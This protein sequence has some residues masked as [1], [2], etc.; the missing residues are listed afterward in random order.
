VWLTK[1]GGGKTFCWNGW[2]AW[3]WPSS[4]KAYKSWSHGTSVFIHMASYEEIV[5]CRCQHAAIKIFFKNVFQTLCTTKWF[6][7]SGH[8]MYLCARLQSSTPKTKNNLCFNGLYSW[9][10][11]KTLKMYM[12]MKLILDEKGNSKGQ[13]IKHPN[14]KES[15]WAYKS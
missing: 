1:R 3:Q 11:L 2:K 7:H 4:M 10:Y 14:K 15:A 8:A 9:L 5:Q 13:Q 12:K 6:L